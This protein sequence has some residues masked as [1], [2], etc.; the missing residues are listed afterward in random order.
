MRRAD[1]A[2]DSRLQIGILLALFTFEFGIGLKQG[3]LLGSVGLF[4]A[5][6]CIAM[7]ATKLKANRKHF[8]NMIVQ[9]PMHPMY[10]TMNRT[11]H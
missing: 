11:G 8:P 7:S 6:L 2:P 10:G 4:G 9:S 5:G 3:S 1:L